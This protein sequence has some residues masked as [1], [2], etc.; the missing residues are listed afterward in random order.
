MKLA[1]ILFLSLIP[2]LF[3]FRLGEEL[4]RKQKLR[5]AFLEFLSHF[6]FQIENFLRDQ[7][8]I[9]SCFDHSLF[10]KTPFFAELEKQIRENPCGAFARTWK[11]HG[12]DFGFD[13]ET[14]QLLSQ[15]AEHFGF[16][17]KNAQ[18]AELSR[19]VEV[20]EK[21]EN[22]GEKE[23]ENKIKILRISGLTAGLGIL[24]LLI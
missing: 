20:L 4:R 9:V 6:H 17:E 11:R 14:F 5:K 8:E 18:L 21:R 13:A 19:A 7:A 16:Q 3:S 2:I 22:D 23:C 15:L 1:G 10:C 12:E 24:I